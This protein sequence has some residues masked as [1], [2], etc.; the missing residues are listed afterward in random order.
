MEY[1]QIAM[2]KGAKVWQGLWH[3]GSWQRVLTWK[4]APPSPAVVH[5]APA[6][7]IF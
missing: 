2:K 6:G 7:V 5:H 1:A 3:E 4:I